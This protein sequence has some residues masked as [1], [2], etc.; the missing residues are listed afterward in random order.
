M[1]NFYVD[2]N[3][4]SDETISFLR[5]TEGS[6]TY[7]MI[8]HGR[9]GTELIDRLK[10]QF[11]L[12]VRY[13][14]DE[15]DSRK[16]NILFDATKDQL[17]AIYSMIPELESQVSKVDVLPLWMKKLIA[18]Q[19]D[20]SS[21]RNGN[22][23]NYFRSQSYQNYDRNSYNRGPYGNRQESH[24]RQRRETNRFE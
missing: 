14:R 15:Q 16:F 18:N 1:I 3:F 24:G 21:S 10:N 6:S 11:N 2:S 4:K 13:Q 12:S 20:Y 17:D 7:T 5:G 19:R 9:V 8:Q 23:N 22:G